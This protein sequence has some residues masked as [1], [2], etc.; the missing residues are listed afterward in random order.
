MVRL[1]GVEQEVG[2][3]R[4]EGVDAQGE[5]GEVRVQG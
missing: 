1:D 5:G 2:G 3:L 4:E